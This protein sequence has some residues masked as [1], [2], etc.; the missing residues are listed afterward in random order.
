[1]SDAS[2]WSEVFKDIGT[3]AAAFAALAG[4]IIALLQYFSFKFT[5]NRD[6]AAATRKSL[7]T[8]VA[9]LASANEVDRLAGAILLRKFFDPTSEVSTRG[10]PYAA[11]AVT[12]IAAILRGQPTGN[13]QKLLADGLAFAPSLEGADLQRTNLQNAY[14]SLHGERHLDLRGADFFRADLAGASLKGANA[15]GAYFFQA[16]MT[17][18]VLKNA[19]LTEA[20]FREADLFGA[21]FDG[22]TLTGAKFD[23]ARN[24][25]AALAPHIKNNLWNAPEGF[26]P[27]AT[28]AETAAAAVVYV[29]KPGC[30][31]A[32]QEKIVALICGWLESH[33]LRTSTLERSD[34]PATSVLAELRRRMSGCAGAIVFG[35]A[36]LRISDGLWRP[37]TADEAKVTGRAWSTP[38][39]HVEAGM[40]AMINLPLLLV[41][42]PDVTNG[43][44]EP[45]LAGH[46][47]Y[48]MTMPPDRLSPDL[49]SWLAAVGERKVRA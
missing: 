27:S 36:E 44:F 30:L 24:L 3:S 45:S 23:G 9:S 31:D 22:A 43:V 15:S 39:N 28:N 14:L 35:F 2:H 25:P 42:E 19:D 10:T 34:Y 33:G 21:I 46:N 37:G 4:A 20:D 12:V 47:V 16:R 17:D 26:K 6:K 32:H 41:A 48:R 13:F 11:D 29:S 8:V 40:A 5:T 49:K 38:W 7:E 1:M 18:A